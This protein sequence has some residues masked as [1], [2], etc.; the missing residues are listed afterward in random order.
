MRKDSP[1]ALQLMKE[2]YTTADTTDE[3]EL[4]L[5]YLLFKPLMSAILLM[6][7]RQIPVINTGFLFLLLTSDFTVRTNGLAYGYRKTCSW[8]GNKGKY[9][10]LKKLTDVVF[11]KQ[12]FQKI[13]NYFGVREDLSI[14]VE[15]VKLGRR[16]ASSFT[17]S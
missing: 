15:F 3:L 12:S 13:M 14:P 17:S 9:V 10:N 2:N 5:R 1:S 4:W 16:G 7:Y 11:K 8:L 6:G